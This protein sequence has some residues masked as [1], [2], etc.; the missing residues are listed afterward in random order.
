MTHSE[1]AGDSETGAQQPSPA[2]AG[3][4]GAAAASSNAQLLAQVRALNDEIAQLR[5]RLA[6]APTDTRP[7]ERQLS[8]S[9]AKINALAERNEK[10][11]ITL[12]EARNQLLQLKEEVDRLG[13]PP[14]GY[15]VFLGPGPGRH[16]R[17]LHR[18]PPDAAHRVPVGRR[19]RAA[20]RASRSG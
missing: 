6:V 7:L 15:G 13:Q 5:R 8:E 17:G 4:T 10:L 18:R 20:R 12:R 16:G 3:F 14:S 19:R 9:S 2:T 11:V 1:S